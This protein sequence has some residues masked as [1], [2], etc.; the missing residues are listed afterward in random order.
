VWVKIQIKKSGVDK[1]I[2][3]K[4]LKNWRVSKKKTDLGKSKLAIF[5]N[6]F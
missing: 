2:K 5:S 4:S 1:K 6:L 3:E